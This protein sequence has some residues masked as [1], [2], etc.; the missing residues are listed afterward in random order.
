MW[1]WDVFC[2]VFTNYTR[3]I[4]C[5]RVVIVARHVII[6]GI[7]RVISKRVIVSV[8]THY[9]IVVSNTTSVI[10][11]V[12]TR[13]VNIT[14]RVVSNT[15]SVVGGVTTT[16]YPTTTTVTHVYYSVTPVTIRV[17][18]PFRVTH[19]SSTNLFRSVGTKS[20]TVTHVTTIRRVVVTVTRHC[21]N[22][23]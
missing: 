21:N 18:V 3:V 14:T 23:P 12:T 1:Q 6:I 2:S 9:P 11:S 13:V 16:H 19:C 5:T 15:T 4:C 8:I 7:T 20:T 17:T 22:T 10:N